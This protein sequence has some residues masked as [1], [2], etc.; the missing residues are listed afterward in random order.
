MKNILI[1][2]DNLTH[3]DPSMQQNVCLNLFREQSNLQA[4]LNK[5]RG[6]QDHQLVEIHVLS[7]AMQ[8]RLEHFSTAVDFYINILHERAPL[9]SNPCIIPTGMVDHFTYCYLVNFTLQTISFP[10]YEQGTHHR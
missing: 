4:T 7:E 5:V 6:L 8:E 1:S 9:P 2:L 3:P 10:I